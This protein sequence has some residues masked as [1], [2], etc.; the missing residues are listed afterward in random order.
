M[1]VLVLLGSGMAGES[2]PGLDGRTF[3]EAADTPAMDRLSAVG[4]SGGWHSAPASAQ[5]SPG[6]DTTLYEL[7]GCFKRTPRGPLEALGSGI[8]LREG[9]VAFRA[10]FVC[11][12][13]GA[14][15]VIMFDSAGGGISDEEGEALSAHLRENFLPDPGEE[16]GFHSL[17]GYRALLTYR[18]QGD[19]VSPAALCGFMPPHDIEGQPIGDYL[20]PSGKARRFVHIVNDSQ[21][22]M[23]GY[24]GTKQ[25]TE[26]AMFPANSIWL[27]GGGAVSDH[28]PISQALGGRRAA[29]VSNCPAVIGVGRLGGAEVF[30]TGGAMSAADCRPEMVAAARRAARSSDFVVVCDEG[31]A[32]AVNRGKNSGEIVGAI[33]AFDREVAGPLIEEMGEGDW[34]ILLLADCIASNRPAPWAMADWN[35][36]ELRPPLFK[37]GFGFAAL[38][39]R[40]RGES[41]A[42]AGVETSPGGGASP[43]AGAFVESLCENR[44]PLTGRALLKRLLAA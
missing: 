8:G 43:E 30:S 6:A 10:N 25:G 19:E 3:L 38:L 18:K 40:L 15:S 9:E 24:Q 36:G 35:S 17:G 21:M 29:F 26:S 11:L 37:E 4:V 7:C 27:W 33:E 41:G 2:F 20:P 13:P 42:S 5:S 44:A 1:K 32:E 12:R 39:R 23:A 28:P 16:I 22:I 31:P 14:T 34:R